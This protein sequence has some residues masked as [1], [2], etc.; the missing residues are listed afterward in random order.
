[1]DQ[2]DGFAATRAIGGEPTTKGIPVV[3]V[4]SKNQKADR[5][6]AQMLG[7]KG[8][9]T[10][11]YTPTRSSARSPPWVDVQNASFPCLSPERHLPANSLT[12]TPSACRRCRR[13]WRRWPVC[14]ARG[15]TPG[16]HRPP[17]IPHRPDAPARALRT[18]SELVEMPTVYPLPR[19]PANL[20]G[21]V[22]LHG[23]IVPLF[24]LAT[25]FETTHL[26]REKRM[27]LVIGHG[28]DAAGIVIDGLP[29]RMVFQPRTTDR[30]AG[31][32]GGRRRRRA[33]HVRPGSGRLV[34]IQLRATTR[35]TR[36]YLT[37]PFATSS[38]PSPSG[39][40]CC[41]VRCS[42]PSS[43]WRSPPSSSA[44]NR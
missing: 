29:R 1:M 22:N 16:R 19:M 3:L 25:L 34:R 23:R 43:R 8:Y 38:A 37:W 41:S 24:D 39:R 4:T 6:W 40:N 20:L 5:V 21:L 26:P 2:M 27:V 30:H 32:A 28:N 10:K 7:V 18:A 31:P 44:A 35:S 13:S 36:E 11:P 9:V 12:R 33:R 15:G 42:S 17:G 14:G